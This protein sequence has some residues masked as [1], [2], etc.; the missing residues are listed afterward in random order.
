MSIKF[1]TKRVGHSVALDFLSFLLSS[2]WSCTS[3]Q[4]WGQFHSEDVLSLSYVWMS[5]YYFSHI[6]KMH[7]AI[8]VT[9]PNKEYILF[10]QFDQKIFVCIKTQLSHSPLKFKLKY[11]KVNTVAHSV[12]MKLLTHCNNGRQSCWNSVLIITSARTCDWFYFLLLWD[13]RTFSH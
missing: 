11:Y 9:N 10:F 2:L 5:T 6:L 13:R 7:N 4:L 12:F 1:Q 3:F 8:M